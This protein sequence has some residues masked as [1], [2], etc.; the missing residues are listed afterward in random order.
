MRQSAYQT[1]ALPSNNNNKAI[2]NIT[3]IQEANVIF[4]SSLWLCVNGKRSEPYERAGYL[5]EASKQN[6]TP[7]T[8][9]KAMKR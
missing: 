6:R 4:P 9:H 2:K 8:K 5:T 1:L 7:K 3:S